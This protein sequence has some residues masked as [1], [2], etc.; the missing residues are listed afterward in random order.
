M[1]K[2]LITKNR[3]ERHRNVM[4]RDERVEKLAKSGELSDE[5]SIYGLPKVKVRRIRKRVKVK[6]QKEAVAETAEK[7]EETE[8][9]EKSEKA[10]KTKK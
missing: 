1:H 8:K 2:S 3:L 9:T 4:T 10:G 7:A 5:D 6:K